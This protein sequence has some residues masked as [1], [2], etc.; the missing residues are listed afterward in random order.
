MDQAAADALCDALEAAPQLTHLALSRS[1]DYGSLP[2]APA[3]LRRLRVL[4]LPLLTGLQIR[5]GGGGAPPGL[6]AARLSDT[7]RHCAG[8]RGLAG[9]G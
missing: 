2:R 7:L 3:L 1:S 4:E 5:R 6:R 8:L 9:R